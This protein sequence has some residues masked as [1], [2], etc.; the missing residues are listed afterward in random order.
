[1]AARFRVR[2]WPRS[3]PE[4]WRGGER[5]VAGAALKA[6]RN[7]TDK[8]KVIDLWADILS[9]AMRG[10]QVFLGTLIGRDLSAAASHRAAIA[11]DNFRPMSLRLCTNL[12]SVRVRLHILQTKMC[13][14]LVRG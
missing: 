3:M 7:D 2:G 8:G 12:L 13:P 5:A 6:K 9:G 11:R 1:M 14:V 10:Q 4:I